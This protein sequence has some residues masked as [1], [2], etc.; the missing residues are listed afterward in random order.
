MQPDG[1]IVVAGFAFVDAPL[2]TLIGLS[3]VTTGMERLTALSE[4][5]AK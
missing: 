4:R 3:R 2:P 5:A 1:K